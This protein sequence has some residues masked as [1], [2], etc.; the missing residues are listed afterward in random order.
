MLHILRITE[1]CHL[2]ES[3]D[4]ELFER[5][6]CEMDEYY[7]DPNRVIVTGIF[8]RQRKVLQCLFSLLFLTLSIL[9]FPFPIS[10]FSLEY[11]LILTF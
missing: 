10:A 6:H 1:A 9:R 11:P 8:S 7:F 5:N 4:E 3:V 2:P